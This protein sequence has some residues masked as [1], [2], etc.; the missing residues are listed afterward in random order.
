MA[1]TGPMSPESGAEEMD[2]KTTDK[3]VRTRKSF[4]E[5][6][7]ERKEELARKKEERARKAESKLAERKAQGKPDAQFSPGIIGPIKLYPNRVESKWGSGSIAGATARISLDGSKRIFR[8]TRQP[9]LTIEGPDISLSVKVEPAAIIQKKAREFVAKVNMYAARLGNAEA[10][11]QAPV[12][13]T[14]GQLEKLG[15]LRDSG[16]LTDEEFAAQKAKLLDS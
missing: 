9:Y 12:V 11:T 3:Q 14:L 8:D 16:V 2:P 7:Q 6:N 4:S 10:E 13:D 15:A 5:I 1:D